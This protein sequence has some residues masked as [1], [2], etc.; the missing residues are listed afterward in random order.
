[1]IKKQNSVLVQP[2][3]HFDLSDTAVDPLLLMTKTQPA[4]VS[5]AST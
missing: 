1:M 2:Q 3:V 5:L 4:E